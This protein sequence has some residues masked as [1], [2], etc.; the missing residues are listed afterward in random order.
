MAEGAPTAD[1]PAA[2]HPEPPPGASAG[3][4]RAHRR[5]RD[6]PGLILLFGGLATAVLAVFGL[7]DA[8]GAGGRLEDL[9][10]VLSA[11]TT[12][13]ALAILARRPGQQI[14]RYQPLAWA[15]A[16]TGAGMIVTDVAPELGQSVS[17][18]GANC[19][20]FPGGLI[21]MAVIVPALYRRLDR[22][23]MVMALLDGGIMLFAGTTLM[24]TFWR[25]GQGSIGLE[26]V[27]MPVTAAA[28]LASAGVAAM[29]ALTLRAA[30]AVRGIWCGIPGVSI[31][32][33]SWTV[34]VDL[35]MRGEPRNTLA[36]LLYSGGILLLGYAWMTW[37]DA[38]GGGRKYERFARSLGDWLPSGAIVLCVVVAA[39]PH[40]GISGIDAVA[41]GTAA[42]VLLS[43]ARQ[44]LLLVSE[45]LASVHLVGEE[46]LRAE[47]EAAETANKAKSAFLA[48]M[49]H[50]IRTPMNAILGNAELLGGAGLG[51]GEHE[52]IQAINDAGQAL[53]SVIN[54]VLDLSKIEADRMS[55][56]RIGFAPEMLVGSV[57][58]LFSVTARNKGLALT[59]EI[60][61]SIPVILAGDPHRLRQVLTNLVGNAIKFTAEGIVIVR[62]QVVTRSAEGTLLRFE[63]ADTGIGIDAQGRDRLFESFVQVDASTTRRFGG[64]GLGL[65]ICKRLVGLMG[66]EFDVDSAP[67]LGS[68]F[69]FTAY[70]ATPTDL[71]A[72]D[73]LAANETVARTGQLLGAQVLVAEDNLANKRLIERLLERLGAEC[74]VVANGL[75][76]VAAVRGGTYDLV[77]MDCHMPEMDGFEAT[78][79]IRAEGNAIPIVALTADAMSGDRD[80]CL[81]VGMDDYL[82]KPIVAADLAATLRRWLSEQRSV[83][84]FA[85]AAFAAAASADTGKGVIDQA[86]VAGLFE[87]DP[88]GS[89]GFFAT[90]V[91]SYRATVAET[92]PG[93]RAALLAG[94]PDALEDAAHKLKGVA[95]N[96]G[97]CRVHESA[98]RLV[99]LARSE[100]T[101][102]GDAILADLEAALGPAEDALRALLEG[103]ARP[104]ETDYQAA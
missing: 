104:T 102:G 68:T 12:T 44:R 87:L 33:L 97:A 84:P 17:A 101:T 78:R 99:A 19:L 55:L 75:E 90:M 94:A 25:T 95:A 41:V 49:S 98:S 13:L 34:W 77:L 11:A 22:Q 92:L 71:E 52:S 16:L 62:A 26:Q 9:Y 24:L 88:D 3:I 18:L 6:R 93:I 79:T 96:L 85:A 15:V 50:E 20:F 80:A 83:G 2:G 36:S 10:V 42:I 72:G 27:F 67:G 70:L 45:R 5:R 47:K 59:A 53:L 31:V 76:A 82:S 66:G 91:E 100:T 64:T 103:A 69:W 40:A 51:P 46:R 73:V 58:S 30:P 32:G 23:A 38:V 21:A 89:D 81:A 4:V 86:Q 61:P 7:L 1:E 56:E 39:I 74:T 28:L 65:V 35:A 57:V 60:D 37:S 29:A 8:G 43:I 14:L 63:V 54:D 48:M